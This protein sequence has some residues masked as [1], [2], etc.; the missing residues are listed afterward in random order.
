[1]YFL[2]IC[3]V[4]LDTLWDLHQ[5]TSQNATRADAAA[6][7]ASEPTLLSGTTSVKARS[8][9]GCR[10]PRCSPNI[11]SSA[12]SEIEKV[13]QRQFEASAYHPCSRIEWLN[14]MTPWKIHR[15]WNEYSMESEAHIY[16]WLICSHYPRV[17]ESKLGYPAGR[18]MRRDYDFRC[19]C[20]QQG[21]R[22]AALVSGSSQR[23]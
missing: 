19:T 11:L 10:R 1:M 8:N 4:P 18:N 2:P 14:T 7:C 15:C 5:L 16:M 3:Y 12:R 23:K 20:P 22:C 9:A 13:K 6:R 17:R 21:R